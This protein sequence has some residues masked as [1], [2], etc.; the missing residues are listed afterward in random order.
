MADFDDWPVKPKFQRGDRVS[1]VILLNKKKTEIFGKIKHVRASVGIV[2]SASFSL[3]PDPKFGYTIDFEGD[4][5]ITDVFEEKE[6]KHTNPLLRMA[7][8]T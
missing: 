2:R 6:I 5:N 7:T 4:L 1:V 8:E 3:V